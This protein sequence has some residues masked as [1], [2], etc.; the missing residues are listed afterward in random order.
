MVE[1]ATQKENEEAYQGVDFVEHRISVPVRKDKPAHADEDGRDLDEEEHDA[2]HN[3][4]VHKV[5]RLVEGGRGDQ[6]M[7]IGLIVQRCVALDDEPHEEKVREEV[8]A[9]VQQRPDVDIPRRIDALIRV[10]NGLPIAA[11][12]P[13]GND[14]EDHAADGVS[15]REDIASIQGLL[16]SVHLAIDS[17]FSC[18][19]QVDHQ[20]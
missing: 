20:A 4:E 15:N 1:D 14:G 2:K 13:H 12:E 8:A 17:C 19:Y 11:D 18:C 7:R 3:H 9:R 5:E 16:D 10:K 6:V